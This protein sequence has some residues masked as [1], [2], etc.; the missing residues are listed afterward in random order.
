MSDFGSSR[1]NHG[2]A[3]RPPHICPQ[4]RRW[5]IPLRVGERVCVWGGTEMSGLTLAAPT[6]LQGPGG[7]R[8]L[9]F[10]GMNKINGGSSENEPLV[11]DA[12]GIQESRVLG[13]CGRHRETGGWVGHLQRAGTATL[14]PEVW[15][16]QETRD[17]PLSR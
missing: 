17:V 10:C 16:L 11:R 6:F 8:P 7:R 13:V 3:K 4:G 5:H 9:E 15:K 14:G 1:I 12:S 2:A